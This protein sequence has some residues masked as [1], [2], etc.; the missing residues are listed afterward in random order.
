MSHTAF[1]VQKDI[2]IDGFLSYS[3]ENLTPEQVRTIHEALT[4]KY[5]MHE[6]IPEWKNEI[7]FGLIKAIESPTN[8]QYHPAIID[9]ENLITR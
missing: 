7:L 4:E 3:I 9:K 2:E 8:Y 1:L 6:D 5:G